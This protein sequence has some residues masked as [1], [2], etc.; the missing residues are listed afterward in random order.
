MQRD[1]SPILHSVSYRLTKFSF[2]S[3]EVTSGF[4][5]YRSNQLVIH[6]QAYCLVY[7]APMA[8]V[9]QIYR[10][11]TRLKSIGVSEEHVAYIF[12]VEK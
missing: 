4:P 8:V 1:S 3:S 11:V 2:N 5:Q 12:R 9:F 7:E 6:T 10:H